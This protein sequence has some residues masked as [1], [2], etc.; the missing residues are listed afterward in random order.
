MMRGGDGKAAVYQHIVKRY[1]AYLKLYKQ[2]GDGTTEG[3]TPF[4]QFYWRFVYYTHYADLMKFL[5]SGY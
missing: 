2:L 1:E 4:D 5:R 3:A